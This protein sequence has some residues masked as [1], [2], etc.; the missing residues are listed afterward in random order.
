MAAP[1]SIQQTSSLWFVNL[2]P[3][4][5]ARLRLFCFPY[6]GGGV[7]GFRRWPQYLSDRIEVWALQLPGRDARWSE[8]LSRRL[9]TVATEIA[10]TSRPF[11]EMP[12]AFFGHSLGALMAFEVTRRIRRDLKV[13]PSRLFVSGCR[14][15]HISYGDLP[16]HKLPDDQLI[17]ELRRLNGTPNTVL[18]SAELMALMLPMIRADLEMIETYSYTAEPPLSCPISAFGGL[19]DSEV[20]L[21]H[22]DAWK[23]HTTGTFS[24]SMLDGDHFF[25]KQAESRLLQ[26]VLA[27]LVLAKAAPA[28][29]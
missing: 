3:N 14:A 24:L 1:I 2:K 27:E 12:F 7:L 4:P 5:E 21:E 18:E 9:L 26:Q 13:E 10:I 19:R 20:R 25:I 16:R 17:N 23:S 29:A 15:P 8:A 22:L 28:A 6:A 11:L